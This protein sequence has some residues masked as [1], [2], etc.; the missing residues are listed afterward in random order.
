M[1]RKIPFTILRVMFTLVVGFTMFWWSI[2]IFMH[3]PRM[4]G[5]PFWKHLSDSIAMEYTAWLLMFD[6]FLIALTCCE[7]NTKCRQTLIALCSILSIV[8]YVISQTHFGNVDILTGL[9]ATLILG[10]VTA[11]SF[12]VLR[13]LHDLERGKNQSNTTQLM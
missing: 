5:R 3:L 12:Y 8:P 9:V 7:K 6:G 2:M 10:S 11:G 4:I 1:S 13:R